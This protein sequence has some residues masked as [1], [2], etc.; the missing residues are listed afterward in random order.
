MPLPIF[1]VTANRSEPSFQIDPIWKAYYSA[2]ESYG[3]MLDPPLL[4]EGDALNGSFW[5][6]VTERFESD[7]LVFFLTSFL[8]PQ[9]A[10]LTWH[11]G[12]NKHCVPIIQYSYVEGRQSR[13]LHESEMQE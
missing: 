2:R 11:L 6:R 4:Q 12:E 7:E 5:H 10:L 1:I 3:A 13:I 8:Y 9:I